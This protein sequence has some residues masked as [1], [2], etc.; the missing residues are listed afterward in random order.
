MF[1]GIDISSHQGDIDLSKLSGV[2]FVIVK[3]T[4]GL[5]YVNPYCD[6]KVQQSIKLGLPFGFYHYA[7]DNDPEKEAQYFADATVGYRGLG[8]PVLDWEEKQ[9]VSWVNKFVKKYHSI[10]GVWP[11]IY[12]NPWRFNQ[13][14]VNPNCGRWVAAYPSDKVVTLDTDPGN[15]PET[16]GLVCCWQYSSRGKVKGYNGN[17]D[18]NHFYGDKTTWKKYA[19][20]NGGN[21]TSSAN[22]P[23]PSN[24]TVLENEKY[25][26]EITEK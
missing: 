1:K 8:I 9:S 26:V 21:S 7:K 18:V 11:W 12:A 6:K 15:I 24:S 20:A 25:K 17:L 16:D 13:G 3:A 10:T 23:T 5:T 4:E 19:K 22:K 14:G 2:Q